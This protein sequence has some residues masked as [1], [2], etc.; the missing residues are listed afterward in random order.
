MS[1]D[2]PEL[3][4]RQLLD[5][6]FVKFDPDRGVFVAKTR[7]RQPIVWTEERIAL[8]KSLRQQGYSNCEIARRFDRDSSSIRHKIGPRALLPPPLNPK[9]TMWEVATATARVFG[10]S[11][12]DLR[13][14]SLLR[15]LVHARAVFYH[16]SRCVMGKSYPQL[17]RFCGGRHH[18]SV[19]F[20][21]ARTT[22]DR[23]F[24]QPYIDAVMAR[25]GEGK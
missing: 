20:G 3:R 19:M 14:K 17:G 22:K 6:E 25:L 23:E 24:Y 1:M 10:V 5:G 7:H 16:V 18:T 12:E 8:A 11:I 9:R 2:D 13:S 4:L 21:C 15:L